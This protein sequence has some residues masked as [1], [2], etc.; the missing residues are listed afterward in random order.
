MAPFIGFVPRLVSL[1]LRR[2]NV[3]EAR[4]A[5]LIQLTSLASGPSHNG[6]SDGYLN[7]NHG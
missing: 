2:I 3:L 4:P 5:A 1:T 7:V 6:G